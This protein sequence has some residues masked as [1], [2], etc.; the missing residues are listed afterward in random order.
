MPRITAPL[1]TLL[2]GASLLLPNTSRA[3]ENARLENGQ[4]AVEFDARAGTIVSLTEPGS[5]RDWIDADA[6]AVPLWE[7]IREDGKPS[8]GPSAAAEF[9]ISRQ[10]DGALRLEW[11]GFA[12]KEAPRLRVRVTARLGEGDDA[13]SVEWHSRIEGIEGLGLAEWRFPRLGPLSK[14]DGETLAAPHWM[15]E[16]TQKLRSILNPPSGGPGL[17]R[18]WPYPGILSMQM[19]SWSAGDG[20]GLWLSTEDPRARQKRMTAR[21]DGKGGLLL[22]VSHL[23]VRDQASKN[24]YDLPYPA[25]IGLSDGGWFGASQAYARWARR[26]DWVENSRLQR[27][28]VPDWMRDTGLWVWNRGKSPGV[29]GPAAVLRER[30]GNDVPVSVFWHWW[31]GCAYDTGFPE[32][33]PPRE[34]TEAFRD[35]LAK[36]HDQGL[37][38]IVY[39]NQRLWGMTT[40]SWEAE[41]A[42]RFAVKGTNG[43]IR[44]EVYNTFNKLPNAAMCMGTPFWRETYAGLAA[45]ALNDLNVDGIYMDQ[46]CASLACYDS[47]HPHPPGG[48]SYWMDGFRAL[49]ADIRARSKRPPGLAGEGCG[50]SWLPHLDAMLSLQVS[51]ERYAAP[52]DWEPIPMFHAVYHD[53]VLTFGNYAS[54]TRPPYDELWP[55]ETAPADRLTLLDR[56]FQRQFRLEQARAFCW[57][58]QPTLANVTQDVLDHREEE[59]DFLTTLARQRRELLPFLRDGT[60]L[61]PIEVVGVEPVTIPTSR[62]SIYAGQQGAVREFEKSVIPVIATAWRAPDGRIAVVAVNIEDHD[63]KASLRVSLKTRKQTITET[64]PAAA[65]RSWLLDP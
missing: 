16:S 47:T 50:E 6:P 52:G 51:V 46:A 5:G 38:A 7:I 10:A 17:A 33:L 59:L 24:E 27:G 39:M 9:Q 14:Q 57:G 44:P 55:A 30:I 18:D 49:E 2:L 20:K 25:R 37:H 41:G 11:K 56:K 21:G 4:I 23:P 35:A 31:H 13:G 61:P 65:S 43:K 42:A 8:I 60:M 53:C 40:K 58:Q 19:L 3:A 15:G 63:V 28:L 48:G 34:G 22:E 64:L 54:L 26:Q 45:E 36:A 12:L 32:Y 29:L 62:L 1:P